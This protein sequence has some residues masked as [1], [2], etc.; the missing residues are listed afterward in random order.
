MKP[1]LWL[2][3]KNQ[4]MKKQFNPEDWFPKKKQEETKKPIVANTNN[5]A[6]DEEAVARAVE[7][8]EKAGVDI[9]GTYESWRNI[10]FALS[11]CGNGRDFFHRVSRFHPEYDA[12]ECDLQFERCLKSKGSSKGS[13]IGLGTFFHHVRSAGISWREE[14]SA[15]NPYTN[16]GEIDPEDPFQGYRAAHPELQAALLPQHHE[17]EEETGA[18]PEKEEKLPVFPE[19]VYENLPD[20]LQ[21]AVA[22]ATSPEERDILLLGSLT[23]L[24]SCFPSVFGIYDGKKVHPNLFLYVTAPAAAGKGRVGL[25]KQLVAQIHRKLREETKQLKQQYEI[26]LAEYNAV[27][28]N[29]AEKP[30]KPPERMLFIPANSSTTGIFQLLSENQARGLIFETEGDTLSQALKSDYG[31]YSDGLRKFFHHETVSYYRR[32]DR[33]YVDLEEPALSTVLT[34]TPKQ[35]SALIPNAE[36]GLFSRFL[37]YYMNLKPEWKDVFAREDSDGLEEHYDELG[38]EFYRFYADIDQQV[39]VKVQFSRRQ[40]REFNDYFA[41]IQHKYLQLQPLDFVATVRRMGLICFRMGM[42]LT[43]IR[44]MEEGKLNPVLQCSDTDF[45]T[46][47]QMVEVCLK[48]GSKVFYSLPEEKPFLARINR[49]E[50]FLEKLPK[51][52]CKLDYLEVADKLKIPH[53]T[54]ANYVTLFIKTGLLVRERK[55]SYVRADE[56]GAF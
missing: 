25:C 44:S 15:G 16:R 8:V 50:L 14:A 3:F 2:T 55:G 29:T 43:V 53:K 49:K 6:A 48:H 27:K 7:A 40:R 9:S 32:T 4:K 38:R 23:T 42:L 17:E 37:F 34:G 5:S 51:E 13:K 24:S 52:F 19:S 47:M 11:Q 54:A 46:V 26:E 56:S 31:N 36:N 45:N 12:Q 10:G 39:P 22:P 18:E 20:F 35:I 41:R 28:N 21:R 33:E 30:V 1:K